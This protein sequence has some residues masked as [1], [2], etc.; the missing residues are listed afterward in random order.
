[1]YLQGTKCTVIIHDVC[2]FTGTARL[3]AF[4]LFSYTHCMINDIHSSNEH[5]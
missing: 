1:M 3:K 2:P 4:H 5:N